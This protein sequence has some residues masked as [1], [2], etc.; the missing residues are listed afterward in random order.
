MAEIDTLGQLSAL[1]KQESQT[2]FGEYQEEAIVSLALDHP[3]FFTTA[4]RFIKPEHFG[5]LECR[6]IIAELLNSFEKFDVIPTR[7]L[8]RDELKKQVTEDDAYEEI[9]RIVDRKSDP[10]EVPIVK[11]SL[12][13][14]S[15]ERAFGM[16]YSDEAVEAYHRG[17]FGHL[18]QIVQEANRIADVGGGGFWFF[19]NME[20]LFQPDIIQH[21][22][23]GF[24]RLDQLLNNG[25]PS[26]KEVVC[27]LAA[28][29]VGKS[30]MLCNNAISSLRGEC[31]D[32]SKGQD[33]LL[34][35]F[36]L[37]TIKTAMRCLAAASGVPIADIPNRQSYIQRVI[38]QMR[39]TYKKRF[40]I[41]EMPP[42]ECSVNHIYALMDSLKRSEGWKPDVVILDYMDL[43]TSRNPAY[44]KD[45]YTRQKHVANEIRGLAKN[46]N[47]LVYTATQT[48]RSG[49]KGDELVDMTKAAE[50]FGKQFSLDYVVSL[51]QSQE[52]RRMSPPRISMF[53]AKNRNGP[54]HET[55]TCE[56]NYDTMVVK[57]LL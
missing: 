6:W 24:A 53:I 41:H 7:N 29:N 37:D 5:R 55:I 15:K 42:D 27:W 38:G 20:M 23:T 2:P 10:R 30:I 35:T 51:N 52:E 33:V 11:E 57:E 21:M 12:L 54:K 17:D 47:V 16:L 25:G 22:T 36:E 50:S 49:A 48:N 39:R 32:G 18:E 8:L 9:F 44:N 26:R 4:A 34:I 28:T 31:S 43:M 45:D 3:E 40:H 13:K 1:S 56:I 46:E 19:E 14:W